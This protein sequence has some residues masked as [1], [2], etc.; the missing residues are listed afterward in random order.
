[1]RQRYRTTP[2]RITEMASVEAMLAL[3][4]REEDESWL[5]SSALTLTAPWNSATQPVV[6]L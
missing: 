6:S 5:S 4:K 2:E 3:Y 1:M